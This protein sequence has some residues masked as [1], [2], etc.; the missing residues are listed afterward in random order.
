M[1]TTRQK[2]L[3]PTAT[4]I[5][6]LG[7]VSC[8]NGDEEANGEGTNDEVEITV[9]GFPGLFAQQ[10]EELV[11]EPYVEE[12][13]DVTIHYEEQ[14]N[15]AD[16]VGQIAASTGNQAYDLAIIDK[17]TQGGANEQG[18]FQQIDSEQVP[19]IDNLIEDGANA[20]GYGPLIYV[21][22]LTLLYN[23][24]SGIEPPTSWGDV[25]DS[26]YE[27]EVVLNIANAMGLSLI[28]GLAEQEGNDYTESIDEEIEFLSEAA[29]QVQSFS[30]NPDV[31]TAVASG[32]AELGIGWY[33]RAIDFAEENP[34]LGVV[35][36]EDGGVALTPT[37]NLVEAAPEEEAALDFL[38]YAIGPEA[39]AALAREGYYGPVSS[40]VDMSDEEL[41]ISASPDGGILTGGTIPD[42]D[43]IAGVTSEWIERIEREVIAQ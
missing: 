14:S 4:A 42:W 34:S 25:G 20:E 19:N 29:D 43:Y 26:R 1:K 40:E 38:N 18:L 15:S 39:Q 12:N 36:P 37:I 28:V 22:S 32:S 35:V 2:Y 31:Y 13:P 11:I 7:L 9:V 6:A 23:T 24:E 41:T 10:F 16:S 17:A 21:D 27:N 30:P 8:G 5:L 3:A 33:A